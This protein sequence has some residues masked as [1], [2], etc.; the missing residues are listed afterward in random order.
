MKKLT[1]KSIGIRVTMPNGLEIQWELFN[2]FFFS[3]KSS[4][5]VNFRCECPIHVKQK[6]IYSIALMQFQY[7]I[8][9]TIFTGEE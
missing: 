7:V 6:F 3:E 5:I 1:S 2:P 9:Q 4:Q 8:H